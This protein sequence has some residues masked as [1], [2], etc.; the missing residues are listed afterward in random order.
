MNMKLRAWSFNNGFMLEP[1]SFAPVGYSEEK[2]LTFGNVLI[3]PTQNGTLLS[4]PLILDRGVFYA[5]TDFKEIELKAYSEEDVVASYTSSV[6]GLKDIDQETYDSL[7]SG[8]KA[9]YEKVL[10]PEK[11]KVSV[12]IEVTLKSIN[13]DFKEAVYA[14]DEWESRLA[15]SWAGASRGGIRRNTVKN[16]YQQ[17]MDGDKALIFMKELYGV[18]KKKAKG[19]QL[20]QVEADF[21][22]YD[23]S[24]SFS[25]HDRGN[26]AVEVLYYDKPYHGEVKKQ[27]QRKTNGR[28]YADRRS[29]NV[30]DKPDVASKAIIWASDLK[31]VQWADNDKDNM[32]IIADIAD[33]VFFT[34]LGELIL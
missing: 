24:R 18:E 15:A 28:P 10:E 30:P 1:E 32:R 31:D 22:N 13:T 20:K 17:S 33:A 27:L 4:E 5:H 25:I 3:S 7:S 11:K 34:D 23:P 8:F 6:K 12:E 21:R 26:S 2:G 19:G 16:L 14:G 9:K 29:I